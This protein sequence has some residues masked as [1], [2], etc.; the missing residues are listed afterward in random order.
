MGVVFQTGRMALMDWFM[1]SVILW[2]RCWLLD[3][4]SLDGWFHRGRLVPG[5]HASAPWSSTGSTH[6]LTA[7]RTA[8]G[9][10]PCF[11]L[12]SPRKW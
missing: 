12:A 11:V 8:L 4:T 5:Y 1:A 3:G 7:L 6:A 9:N 10:G 2:M